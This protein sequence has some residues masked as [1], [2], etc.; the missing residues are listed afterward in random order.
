MSTE[1]LAR[2]VAALRVWV[3]ILAVAVGALFAVSTL[4]FVQAGNANSARARQA[5]GAQRQASE[6]KGLA[7]A[8]IK[9]THEVAAQA[10][11]AKRLA[12]AIQNQGRRLCAEDNA[13]HINTI[14]AFN[15]LIAIAVRRAKTPARRFQIQQ[16]AHSS[17]LIVDALAPL[18]HCG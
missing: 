4:A 7:Q 1:I 9:L 2:T 18:P 16:Q 11:E 8:N 15:H 14:R 10:A 5:A 12:V 13:R 17:L 6:A 3:A